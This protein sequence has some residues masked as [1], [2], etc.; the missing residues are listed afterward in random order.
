MA[1]TFLKRRGGG[2]AT[3]F[4]GSDDELK[5]EID[6]LTAQNR[7]SREPETERRLLQLRHMAGM[8]LVRGGRG[9]DFVAPDYDALPPQRPDGLIELQAREVT[10]GLIRAALLR[11]GAL[12]VRGLVPR[13]DALRLADGIEHA[14]AARD[15]AEDEGRPDEAVYREFAPERPYPP[16]VTREWIR[17]GGGVLGADCPGLAFELQ[18]LFINAGVPALAAG[19]LGEPAVFSVDKTT[20]RKATPDIPGGW[21]QDGKFMGDVR[22]LNLWL[23]LSRCGDVAPGLD[24]V[25]RRFEG[26][27]ATQ[28]EEAILDYQVSQALAEQAAGDRPIIRPIF[29]PGDAVFFD[30][31]NLHKTGSDPAMP[32]PRFAV[33]NWFFGPSG[34]PEAYVPVAV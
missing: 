26:M 19:Y 16:I 17:E 4:N 27:V 9:A 22:A 11:D 18:E 30:E 34:F 6:R 21:H 15:Q 13:E 7:L 25:A 23:S 5:A 32:N 20:L 29:E 24:L 1:R 14:V 12:I 8:R 33:E 10:P 3:G 31:M 28:T 2:S